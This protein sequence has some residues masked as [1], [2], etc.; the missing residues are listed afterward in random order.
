MGN[1]IWA[2]TLLKT[3]TAFYQYQLRL[4]RQLSGMDFAFSDED[5]AVYFQ[6]GSGI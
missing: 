2:N 3:P 4:P 6:V 5:S 1:W